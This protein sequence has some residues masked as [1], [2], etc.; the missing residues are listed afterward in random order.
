MVTAGLKLSKL[1]VRAIFT[2]ILQKS[3]PDLDSTAE[4]GDVFCFLVADLLEKLAFLSPEQ[5]TLILTEI[6]PALT[7][8]ATETIQLGFADQQYCVWTGRTGWLDLET[9]EELVGLETPFMETIGYNLTEL[10]R[11]GILM[12][13]NRN[14]FHVKKSSAGSVD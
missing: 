11:R 6:K 14:G 5:R 4:P 1:Q 3:I 7:V 9:G 13:E 8:P 12:L 10:Y 2:T